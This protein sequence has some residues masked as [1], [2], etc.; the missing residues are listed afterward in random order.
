MVYH[1][2]TAA[3]KQMIIE[4]ICVEKEV[5][6]RIVY[7]KLIHLFI[8]YLVGLMLEFHSKRCSIL[9]CSSKI[10]F[11]FT[12]TAVDSV[13]LFESEIDVNERILIVKR[14][15]KFSKKFTKQTIFMSL[16]TICAQAVN[17]D[18]RNL[19]INIF[20]FMSNMNR[21]KESNWRL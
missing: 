1:C 9:L 8:L 12:T 19:N 5:V 18:L 20:G 21:S 11:W 10:C 16:L 15:M 13:C 2:K 17:L 3:I 7:L 14:T 6:S 4:V